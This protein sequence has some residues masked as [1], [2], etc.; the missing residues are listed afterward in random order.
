[1]TVTHV[2]C[3][4]PQISAASLSQEATM[5]C[6]KDTRSF[7]KPAF[8]THTKS[9]PWHTGQPKE[10]YPKDGQVGAGRPC[11]KSK[12]VLGKGTIWEALADWDVWLCSIK[13][14]FEARYF[15]FIVGYWVL[16]SLIHSREPAKA[17]LSTVPAPCQVTNEDGEL[18]VHPNKTQERAK[19]DSELHLFPLFQRSNLFCTQGLMS[20]EQEWEQVTRCVYQEGH[21][22]LAFVLSPQFSFQSISQQA[23]KAMWTK[24][25]T[26]R[27]LNCLHS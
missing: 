12:E 22:R 15:I 13:R 11:A 7:P 2:R 17:S 25:T 21:H 24:E 9:F 10:P 18:W 23:P 26:V 8:F 14:S 20:R 4:R 3:E 1:M 16:R 5:R 19:K 6:L 27:Y